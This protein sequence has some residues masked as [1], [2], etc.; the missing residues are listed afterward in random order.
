MPRISKAQATANMQAA[1]ALEAAGVQ[2]AAPVANAPVAVAPA[3]PTIVIPPPPPGMDKAVWDKYFM[4]NLASQVKKS[5]AGRVAAS[6]IVELTNET[7]QKIHD[8]GNIAATIR[9]GKLGTIEILPT[10][11]E[12]GC[13]S[14]AV[15]QNGKV[16]HV[17]AAHVD[18]V[19]SPRHLPRALRLAGTWIGEHPESGFQNGP[20]GKTKET[21]AQAAVKAEVALTPAEVKEVAATGSV[22][23]PRAQVPTAAE[24]AAEIAKKAD[25]IAKK[26]A[27]TKTPAKTATKTTRK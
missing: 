13:Y 15:V 18:R 17:E 7:A 10:T 26:N 8:A 4:D 5:S 12:E 24:K 19:K 11:G 25:A 21:P 20:T 16:T 1:A 9:A 3:A 2:P 23:T 27:A 6:G 14:L 22:Q